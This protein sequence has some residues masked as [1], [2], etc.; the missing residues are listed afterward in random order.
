MRGSVGILGI[1]SIRRTRCDRG[2]IYREP[3]SQE[4]GGAVGGMDG[5]LNPWGP[6]IVIGDSTLNVSRHLRD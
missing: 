1:Y 4:R 2:S 3:V 5:E 6:T